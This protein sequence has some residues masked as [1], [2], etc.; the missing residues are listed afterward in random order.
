VFSLGGGKESR[1][2]RG[3]L[4]D[5]SVE[6]VMFNSGMIPTMSSLQLS[7][8]RVTDSYYTDSD[9]SADPPPSDPPPSSIEPVVPFEIG[10]QPGAMGP[11]VIGKEP[12]GM[13]A[14]ENSKIPKRPA[15]QGPLPGQLVKPGLLD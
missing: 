2:L 14:K 12:P 6:H 1:K 9:S 10:K 15:D 11:Y 8:L 4:T 3:M 13:A 7:F 5:V